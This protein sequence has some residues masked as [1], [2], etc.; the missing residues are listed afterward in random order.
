MPL[1]VADRVKETTTTVGT[2]TVTLAGPAAGFQSF[3]AIGNGNTTYYTI[4]DSTGGNWEVGIGTYSSSGSTTL[5][6]NT[7]LS[8][9]NFGNLVSFAAGI[10]EVFVTYPASRSAFGGGTQGILT[11]SNTVNESFTIPT[12]TNGFS[13][14][15][16]TIGSGYA[17]TV[18][19]GQRWVVI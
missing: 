14:G 6:R 3:A 16:I 10:K 17:V 13:V 11:N 5:A 2:G 7:V 1:V 4:V 18:S 12:G 9:S 8:S 19:S 15:P